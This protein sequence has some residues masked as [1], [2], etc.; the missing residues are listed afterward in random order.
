MESLAAAAAPAI[1]D[2]EETLAA[3]A[4]REGPFA[5]KV[6]A[7]LLVFYTLYFAARLLVPIAFAIL[8]SMLLAPLVLLLERI[9]LP[10]AAGAAVVVLLAMGT[11]VL[12]ATLLAGPAQSWLE[13]APEGFQR[14]EQMLASIRRPLETLTK[15]TEQLQNATEGATGAQ[16]QKVVLVRP[17]LTEFI[18]GTPQVLAP[19]VS[20]FLL[21]F[22]LLA[23]GDIFLRKLVAVV[24]T[25]RE[26][27][28]T[29]EIIRAIEDDISYYLLTFAAVNV[30]IGIAVGV[31][32][33]LLGIP[34]P[35]LWGALVA[36]LNF[37][38]YIGSI[39]S[40]GILAM[41]GFMTFD[42]PWEAMAAPAIMLV[43][44]ALSAEV[45]TPLVLGR[46][47]RLN[48]VAIFIAI[49]LWGWLWGIVGVLLAVPLLASF[50]IICERVE[51][52]APIAEFL[53]V[54]TPS[55]I[56]TEEQA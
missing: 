50:K 5:L 52:L 1:P 12:G 55:T 10:R 28:R 7:V 21:T 40:M 15:A 36:V 4:M 20:V 26:K 33:A 46:G 56:A 11:V 6:I 31:A 2:V 54:Y 32:T 43:F 34:N 47:L 48:P 3:P 38:P 13:K 9:R 30:G 14:I 42:N 27:K 39:V 37:V 19:L 23:A 18:M 25:F 44:S 29:V 53:T 22:F 45:V 49:M 17:A 35:L 16:P 51:P 24:P 8:L 41:V